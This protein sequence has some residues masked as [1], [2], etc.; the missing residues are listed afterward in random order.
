MEEMSQLNYLDLEPVYIKD[1]YKVNIQQ[2]RSVQTKSP[3]KIK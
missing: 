1:V 3:R 2:N